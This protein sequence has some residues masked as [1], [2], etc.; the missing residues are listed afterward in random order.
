VPYPVVSL[1]GYTNAGKS[2]LFNR[3]VGAGVFAADMLFA[4]LDPTMRALQLPSGQRVILSDTVGFISDIPLDLVAAFRATL[5]EV[6]GADLVLHVRDIA[7]P[8]SDSQRDD[9]NAVLREL[10]LGTLLDA[11][12]VIEVLNKIDLLPAEARAT[13]ENQVQRDPGLVPVSAWSGEGVPMLLAAIEAR[14][15]AGRRVTELEIA[16]ADGAALAWLYR[17][18]EVLDRQDGPDAIRLQVRLSDADAARFA[19]RAGLPSA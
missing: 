13:I 1:V 19:R 15:A 12:Q 10:G 4:T 6:V 16:P 2:T 18:G 9:V 17:H 7:N 11:G 14:L 8:D 5:E 3:M